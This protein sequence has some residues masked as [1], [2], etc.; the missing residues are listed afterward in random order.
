MHSEATFAVSNIV[1]TGSRSWR[2]GE[3][4]DDALDLCL[5]FNRRMRLIQG[6]AAG[7][8]RLA[9]EWAQDRGVDCETFAPDYS[10]PSPQRYHERNDRMLDKA[11][12]V[13][14]FWD[15]ESRGTKSVIDKARDRGL[16]VQVIR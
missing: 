13:I 1:V 3:K 8:D 11:D 9:Y 10:R 15:G 14:A 4:V 12:Q 2:N 6:G 7:A 5:A 16:R